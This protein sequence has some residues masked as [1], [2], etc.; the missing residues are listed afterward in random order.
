MA[1]KRDSGESEEFKQEHWEHEYAACRGEEQSP[2][3]VQTRKTKYSTKMT[4]LV[5]NNYDAINTWNISNNGETILVQPASGV[6]GSFQVPSI[7]GSNLQ[8]EFFLVQFHFHWGAN[9]LQGSEHYIGNKRSLF[10]T[11]KFWL[12][13]SLFLFRWR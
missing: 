5:F 13:F 12:N 7:K 1:V 8:D 6:N 11:Y 3:N 4:P 2:I 10:S 9:D